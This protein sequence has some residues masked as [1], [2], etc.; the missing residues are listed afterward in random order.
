MIPKTISTSLLFGCGRVDPIFNLL[1]SMIIQ[2]NGQGQNEETAGNDQ[3]TKLKNEGF[4][5][6]IGSI[7]SDFTENIYKDFQGDNKENGKIAIE[8]LPVYN[9]I[10]RCF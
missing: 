10:F 8:Y 5:S 1:Y 7:V 9:N 4:F 2:E 3:K 6:S